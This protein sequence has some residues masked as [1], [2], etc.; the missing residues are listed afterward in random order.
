MAAPSAY[1]RANQAQ[2]S[3]I[4]SD[5]FGNPAG[6]ECEIADVQHLTFPAPQAFRPHLAM[7]VALFRI[8]HC[9]KRTSI[10][11]EYTQ[12]SGQ[13]I[14]FTQI[15]SRNAKIHGY[16]ANFRLVFFTRTDGHRRVQYQIRC[17][18]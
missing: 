18:L 5:I 7:G 13:T 12:N 1:E 16:D 8:L 3:R 2:K 9:H 14:V 10:P 17:K 11:Q 15:F 4:A 6:W